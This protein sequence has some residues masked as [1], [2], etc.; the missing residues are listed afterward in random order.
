MRGPRTRLLLATGITGVVVV[1]ALLVAV[2]SLASARLS[3]RLFL[4]YQKT[5]SPRLFQEFFQQQLEATLRDRLFKDHDL[6]F[7]LYLRNDQN[8]T[9]NLT[10]RRYRGELQLAHRFYN[11]NAR[12]SPKQKI[13][14]IELQASKE[15]IENQV[16]VD[17]HVP[18]APRFRF[19]VGTRSRYDRGV[20]NGSSSEYRGDL[21]YRLKMFDF[22]VNRW[23]T[24]SENHTKNTTTVTGGSARITQPIGPWFLFRSGYDYQLTENQRN[25]GPRLTTDNHTVR[26]LLNGNL[27]ETIVGSFS[28]ISRRLVPNG[29]PRPETSDD[30][31]QFMARAFP[32]FPLHVDLGWSYLSSKRGFVEMLSEYAT[33]QLLLEG[34]P[35]R[36]VFGRIQLTKRFVIATRNGIVPANIFFV[37][38]R[39][40]VYQGIDLQGE[41]NVNQQ[42]QDFALVPRYQSYTNLRLFMRPTRS[43]QI[44]PEVRFIKHSD[45]LSLSNFGRRTYRIVAVYSV[46]NRV[47]A[48]FNLRKNIITNGT[49]RDE[50]AAT[51]NVGFSLRNRSSLNLSYGINEKEIKHVGSPT[52]A[53]LDSGATTFN[54]QAIVWITRRGSLTGNY[55]NVDRRNGPG[56]SYTSVAYR[57]DF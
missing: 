5:S 35:R 38:L 46:A 10:F 28:L 17:L 30:N 50:L 11:V 49:Q 36:N 42:E 45:K 53:F 8:L 52:L 15:T 33:A 55:S 2:E 41:L 1:A 37:S 7:S 23:Y 22:E 34:Q 16:A 44:N 56:S 13:T 20:L 25:G 31:I 32:K 19:H 40:R 29:E 26:A 57:Q 51:L 47:N 21:T 54:V 48:G 12:F 43:I 6:R 9:N 3:G 4:T 27:K 24:E 18:K 14:P 39:S